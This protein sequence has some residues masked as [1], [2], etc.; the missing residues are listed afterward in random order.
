MNLGS[1]AGDWPYPGENVYGSTEAFVKQ[2][3]RSLR[4]D[5]LGTAIRV[6]SVEPGLAESEFSIVRFKG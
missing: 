6:T 1:V 2:F 3:S 4:R 5:L